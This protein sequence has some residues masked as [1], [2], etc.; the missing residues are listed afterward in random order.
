MFQTRDSTDSAQP[1]FIDLTGATVEFKQTGL[2]E[3][4]WYVLSIQGPNMLIPFDIATN[5]LEDANRWHQKI[6]EAAENASADEAKNKQMERISRIA[7]EMSNLAVYCRSVVFNT[8]RLT[9][10]RMVF[11][12]H[13]MSSFPETQ[14]EKI[15]CQKGRSYFVKYHQVSHQYTSRVCLL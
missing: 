10:D 8:D 2:G 14:A 4:P 5:N 1:G 11:N 13:E 3:N 12:I 15:I 7:K 9:S 6:R